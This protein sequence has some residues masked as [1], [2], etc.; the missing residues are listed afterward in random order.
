MSPI[1]EFTFTQCISEQ[2]FKTKPGNNECKTIVFKP[3]E[4][5]IKKL[6]DYATHGGVFSP[7]CK[8]ASIDGS[9]NIKDKNKDNFLST[10]TLFFDFD[11][12]DIPM[13]DFVSGL[14]FKPS[15]GY[16]SYRNGMDGFRFRLGYVFRH[17]ITGSQNF[18]ELYCAIYTE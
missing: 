3:R 7:T 18:Q 9:F 4:V 5:T 8:S 11:K 12:M 10:S 2:C 16:T 6:L 14:K 15:F 13:L 17:P 1:P